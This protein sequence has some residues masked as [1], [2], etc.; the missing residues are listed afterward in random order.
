MPHQM[1]D[2]FSDLSASDRGT[3]VTLFEHPTA[4]NL[5]WAA[6]VRLFGH[7]GE[8]E[9][10][11]N[12]EFAF[13]V[14]G[15]HL[16]IRKPHTKDLTAPDVLDFRHFA[17]R[18]GWSPNQELKPTALG[19]SAAL[20]FLVVMDHH[21]A[22]IYLIEA[23]TD[24]TKSVIRPYD[25]HHFLHQLSHKD[26]SRERGQWAH[27]DASFYERIAQ[28]VA[29]GGKIVL[30]GHGDGKS[31][32]A[33]HLANYLDRHHHQAYSRV[34]REVVAD[35]SHTTEPQLLEIARRALRQ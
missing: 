33:H 16:T 23:D 8:V 35:L 4:H 12:D 13:H 29:K 31:N 32:A 1:N 15:D 10:K 17:A 19:A 2:K 21:E 9:E 5:T 25:P 18:L 22:R 20:S 24:P 27:E 34:T 6:I 11:T 30:V 3:L 28:T 7:L 14:G 26:Q